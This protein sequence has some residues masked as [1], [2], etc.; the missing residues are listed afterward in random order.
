MHILHAQRRHRLRF[1]V[2]AREVFPPRS[3]FSLCAIPVVHNRFRGRNFFNCILPSL[4]WQ[5][6][7]AQPEGALDIEE[8]VLAGGQTEYF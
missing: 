1:R 5:A 4:A 7:S 2:A 8:E 3:K 6:K